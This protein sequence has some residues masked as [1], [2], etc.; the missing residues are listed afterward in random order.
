MRISTALNTT[1]S[2]IIAAAVFTTLAVNPLADRPLESFGFQSSTG[3][4]TYSISS[5]KRTAVSVSDKIT[6]IINNLGL[7]VKDLESILGV[8]RASIYNWKNGENQPQDDVTIAL[9]NK[10]YE[11]AETLSSVIEHKFGRL[12]KTH[13]YKDSDYIS[14]IK[15]GAKSDDIIEHAKELNALISKRN[16]IPDSMVDGSVT[17]EAEDFII[18]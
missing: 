9:I 16:N 5:D 12:A 3:N 1:R 18:G 14:K 13:T 4:T 15:N 10:T 6:S 8:K 17:P 7:N 11:L 2:V